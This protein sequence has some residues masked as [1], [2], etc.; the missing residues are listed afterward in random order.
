MFNEILF[1]FQIYSYIISFIISTI[2]LYKIDSIKINV[3]NMLYWKIS[4]I[5]LH[6]NKKLNLIDFNTS[7]YFSPMLV[8]LKMTT[9][10]YH[11]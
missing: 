11:F 8:F 6:V 4:E 9:L 10:K 2:M 3:K 7:Y 1:T 5:Y